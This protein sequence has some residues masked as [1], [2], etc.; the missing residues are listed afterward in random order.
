M[1]CMALTSLPRIEVPSRPI[2]HTRSSTKA[3]GTGCH[4]ISLEKTFHTPRSSFLTLLKN[5]SI[6]NYINKCKV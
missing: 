4:T 3:N 2:N 1:S 6:V 5:C